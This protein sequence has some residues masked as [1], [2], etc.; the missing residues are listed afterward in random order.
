MFA[1]LSQKWKSWSEVGIRLPFIHDS[2]TGKPS[3]TLLFPYITFVLATIS[4][5]LLHI[6]TDL[7]VATWTT[8]GF[9]IVSTVLYMLRRISKAKFDLDDKSIELDSGDDEKESSPDSR[10]TES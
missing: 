5:I 8:I 10:I 9:W 1:W 4:I 7:A 6:K 2:T 3:I